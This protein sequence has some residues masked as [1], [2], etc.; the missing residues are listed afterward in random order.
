G[1]GFTDAAASLAPPARW[2]L[3]P[4]LLMGGASGGVGGGIRALA[5]AVVI[6]G[7]WRLLRGRAAGKTFAIATLWL[8]TMVVLFGLTFLLLVEVSPQLRP[9]RIAILAA[10]AVG[11]AGVS[12]DPVTAAGADGYVLAAAMLLG[13]VLP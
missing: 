5:L 10:G 3:V 2:A 7:L 13:R 1:A 9:D 4:V 12:V 8:A 6:V 11:G